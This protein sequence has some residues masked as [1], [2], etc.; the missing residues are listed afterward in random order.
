M[1]KVVSEICRDYFKKKTLPGN[2]RTGAICIGGSCLTYLRHGKRTPRS[3]STWEDSSTR[4]LKI[5]FLPPFFF[6]SIF[7]CLYTFH[8]F[9]FHFLL[10]L[11]SNLSSFSLTRFFLVFLL[12]YF[13]FFLLNIFY[14][15]FQN[16]FYPFAT[17]MC[18]IR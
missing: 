10:Q 12:C 9:A 4:F 7:S 1:F 14:S 6:S 11:S 15:C 3:S 8:C 18:L 17:K 16:F 2:K 5:L 13:F